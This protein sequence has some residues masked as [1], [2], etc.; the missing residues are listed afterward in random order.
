RNGIYLFWRRK[1]SQPTSLYG[2]RW[3]LR[4]FLTHADMPILYTPSTMQRKIQN[5]PMN[6]FGTNYI[7]CQK[8]NHFVIA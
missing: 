8:T 3:K 1:E 7:A 5:S 2:I 6:C 4:S